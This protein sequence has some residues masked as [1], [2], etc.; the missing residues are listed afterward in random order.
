MAADAQL[1]FNLSTGE[2]LLFDVED[3][4]DFK[5]VVQQLNRETDWFEFNGNVLMRKAEIIS[6]YYLPEGFDANNKKDGIENL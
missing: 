1:L 2:R 4:E 6:V 5:F 3:E